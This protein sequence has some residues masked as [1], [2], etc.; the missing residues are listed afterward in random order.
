[1][2]RGP[3]SEA[4]TD[5][6]RDRGQLLLVAGL[7][8]AVAFV[9]LAL[10][11][12]SVVF[13]HNLATRPSASGADAMEYQ[14]VVVE[15]V[16]GVLA[17]ANER[18]YVRHGAL[19]AAFRDDTA[20]WANLTLRQY[21]AQGT[22]TSVAI[23]DVTNGT[24]IHQASVREFTDRSG[25]A[26]W[27]LFDDADGARRF[28]MNLTDDRS[29][30]LTVTTTF[31]DGSTHSVDVD[32]GSNV[33]VDGG[34]SAPAP[35]TVDF[36][37]ASVDGAHCAALEGFTSGTV[38]E[39]AFTNGD[40]VTGRY[41]V[42]A[43]ATTGDLYASGSYTD[44]YYTADTPSP[45]ALDAV[46][47]ATLN[48]TYRAP[49]IEY[50]T[51]VRLE[52]DAAPQGPR[53]G[54]VPLADRVVFTYANDPTNLSTVDALGGVTRFAPTNATV[55][56][57]REYD[58]TGDDVLD[59]PY[60]NDSGDVRLAN[61][62]G[63]FVIAENAEQSGS[64]LAV[65]SWNGSRP[66]VFYAGSNN[67]Y[68]YRV[69]P[70]MD[71]P[72]RLFADLDNDGVSAVSGIGDIDGDGED[73]LVFVDNSGIVTY[74]DPSGKYDTAEGEMFK[75]YTNDGNP[76]GRGVGPPIDFDGDGRAKIP[77]VQSSHIYLGDASGLDSESLVDDLA[78]TAPMAGFDVDGDGRPELVY[79]NENGKIAY[80]DDVTAS[81]NAI[82]FE[83]AT[84]S[85]IPVDPS[86]GVA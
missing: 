47:A 68:V 29:G 53:Y 43:N 50:E 56:G 44:H 65:G 2:Q 85:Q 66:S 31:A 63:S 72:E 83:N 26:D 69:N 49:D 12:N 30:T 82:K 51:Q 9:A 59:T 60:V 80:I 55:I 84:G 3:P 23:H 71:T 75:A 86:T 16:G 19:D 8:I 70:S 73:E 46:Y 35:A 67:D 39:I 6:R 32:T 54:V 24:G 76:S 37:S 5:Q 22:L 74:H 34:C 18:E 25:A 79:V 1:M 13:T 58:F 81:A 7:G 45:Y 77:V 41:V 52:P 10:V 14:D 21:A 28:K 4:A 57:P 78:L 36:S 61:E 33:T 20:E 15:G 62:S 48:L 17:E 40:A 11:V 27:S 42:V 38:E 64:L